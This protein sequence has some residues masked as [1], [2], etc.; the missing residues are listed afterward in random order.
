MKML[1]TLP[2]RADFGPVLE[3][4]QPV[5]GLRPVL[6]DLQPVPGLR[7]VLGDLQWGPGLFGKTLLDLLS[8]QPLQLEPPLNLLRGWGL[9]PLWLLSSDN[10]QSGLGLRPTGLVL[11]SSLQSLDGLGSRRRKRKRCSVQQ[12]PCSTHYSCEGV[13]QGDDDD[14]RNRR[15]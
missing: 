4:L 1:V 14:E 11:S 12:E 6:E 2:P 5:P 13:S 8:G 15:C 3:D 7:P 10:L 9:H